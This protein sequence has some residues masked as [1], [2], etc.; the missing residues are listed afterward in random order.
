MIF[1]KSLETRLAW[2]VVDHHHGI[3]DNIFF[4][5]R[6]EEEYVYCFDMVAL[7]DHLDKL[8]KKDSKKDHQIV[9][10]EYDVNIIEFCC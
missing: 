2:D 5:C 3:T 10:L 7:V 9:L 4:S 8:K 6:T 1:F